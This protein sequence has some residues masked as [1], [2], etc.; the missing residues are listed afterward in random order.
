MTAGDTSLGV[1]NVS[2]YPRADGPRQ[3]TSRRLSVSRTL[4]PVEEPREVV[5]AQARIQHNQDRIAGAR[6]G[7]GGRCKTEEGEEPPWRDH[8][9]ECER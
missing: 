9:R 4:K 3:S 6:L 2:S 5:F 8:G 1:R 7:E